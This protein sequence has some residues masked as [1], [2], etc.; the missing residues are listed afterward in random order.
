MEPLQSNWLFLTLRKTGSHASFFFCNLLVKDYIKTHESV[1]G[2]WDS[3]C[4]L[5]STDVSRFDNFFLTT[6]L[7]SV[8]NHT[9]ADLMFLCPH[10]VLPQYFIVNCR[11]NSRNYN[12][13]SRTRTKEVLRNVGRYEVKVLWRSLS[14]DVMFW[15]LTPSPNNLQARGREQ[16]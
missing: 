5:V 9:K 2:N 16:C 7:T 14:Q 12:A 1:P 13:H 15:S 8:E 4:C 3:T 10:T 6:L 11:T